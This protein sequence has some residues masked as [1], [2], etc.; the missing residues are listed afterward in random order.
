MIGKFFH[1]PL[2]VARRQSLSEKPLSHVVK[3]RWICHVTRALRRQLQPA[4][5]TLT[6]QEPPPDG[7]WDQE[8]RQDDKGHAGRGAGHSRIAQSMLCSE[9]GDH[10]T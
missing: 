8:L 5:V 4:L 7:E 6:P 10:D 9:Y 2:N 1:D 3:P